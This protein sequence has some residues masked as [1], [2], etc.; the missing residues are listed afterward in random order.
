MRA[1][2]VAWTDGNCAEVFE[3]EHGVE[4]RHVVDAG[5]GTIAVE[6]GERAGVF[7]WTVGEPDGGDIYVAEEGKTYGVNN[8]DEWIVQNGGWV[9]ND[10]DEENG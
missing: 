3:D 5:D 9:E 1:K 2:V 8:E 6:S 4:W 10:E 7:R